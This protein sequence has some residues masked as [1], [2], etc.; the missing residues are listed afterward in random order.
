MTN[1]TMRTERGIGSE[2]VDDVGTRPETS[3]LGS[4]TLSAK[5]TSRP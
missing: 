1:R 4:G 3:S 2:G 5:K